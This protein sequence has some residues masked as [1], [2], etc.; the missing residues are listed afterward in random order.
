MN[1]QNVISFRTVTTAILVVILLINTACSGYQENANE[2]KSQPS[3]SQASAKLPS[4]D[5]HAATVTG[6]L[7]VINQ[8]ILAGSNLDEKDP[9]E[10]SSALILAAVFGK[11]EIAKVLIESGADLHLKNKEGSTA[12]HTAAFFCRVEIVEMLLD[13]GADKSIR[14]NFGSTAL[15]SVAIPF[16]EV[17]VFYDHLSNQLGQFGLKLDYERLKVTRPKIAEMLR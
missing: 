6:N 2:V 14:N 7:E 5:I 16:N 10:G 15:E 17:K 3:V 8:H 11:T 9:N 1:E 12:L 13:K 4:V